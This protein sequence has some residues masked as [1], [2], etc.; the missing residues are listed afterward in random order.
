[1]ISTRSLPPYATHYYGPDSPLYAPFDT[2]RGPEYHANPNLLAEQRITVRIPDAPVRR[3]GL[4]VTAALVDGKAGGPTGTLEYRLGAAG[5]AL[6]GVALYS[7]VAAR[8]GDIQVEK[9]TFDDHEGH[10]DPQRS[11]HYHGASKGPLAVLAAAGVVT[12]TAPGAAE[13]ELYGVMCDGTWVLGC[14]ELDGAAPDPTGLDAQ[15]GHGHAMSDAA[16][17]VTLGER[18][19]VHLCSAWA[20][21]SR[22][23]TPEIQVHERCSP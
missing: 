20:G 17:A 9:Y 6:N 7:G 13:V 22:I 3:A 21:P 16:G 10:P 11:Y 2:S 19:H 18:Y 15:N 4:V 8:G 14:T 23:L 5:V 12:R 1:M